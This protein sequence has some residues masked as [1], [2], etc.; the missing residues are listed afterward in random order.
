MIVGQMKYYS[1]SAALSSV[2]ITLVAEEKVKPVEI[3]PWRLQGTAND[4][5]QDL[6]SFTQGFTRFLIRFVIFNLPSLILIAIPLYGIF[7]GGRA[8]FRRF[9]KTKAVVDV[10][11]K[12]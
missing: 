8:L 12:E 10:K 9:R 4:A 3:G 6:I 11:E 1:E 5:A 7:I 2:N